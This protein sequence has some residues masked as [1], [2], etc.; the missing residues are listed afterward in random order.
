VQ[1]ATQKESHEKAIQFFPKVV[2]S[3]LPN[4]KIMKWVKCRVLKEFKA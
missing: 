3:Q 1:I 2:I 4:A